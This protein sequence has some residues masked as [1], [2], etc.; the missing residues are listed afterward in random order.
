MLSD[1]QVSTNFQEIEHDSSQA[2]EI[3]LK[4]SD[5]NW[6]NKIESIYLSQKHFL[7][8][9][10]CSIL[11]VRDQYLALE[12]YHRIKANEHSFEFLSWHYGEGEEKKTGGKIVDKRLEVIPQ[13]LHSLFRKV[14][15]GEVLKPHQIGDWY[16]IIQVH[17]FNPAQF[18]ESTKSTL[19]IR[20]FDRWIKDVQSLLLDYLEL[21]LTPAED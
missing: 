17:D 3:F 16:F 13:Q 20:E 18:D 19:L 2:K 14:R 11:R 8:R 7:D 1:L 12:L 15:V 21:E 9:V 4:W 6:G 5:Y 10:T